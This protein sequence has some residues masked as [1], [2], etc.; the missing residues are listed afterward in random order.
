MAKARKKPSKRKAKERTKPTSSMPHVF[1]LKT[2]T[3]G[4]C[5]F[6]EEDF[7]PLE[8]NLAGAINH[9]VQEHD[10]ELLHI[11]TETSLEEDKFFHVSVAFLEA[12]THPPERRPKGS[13]P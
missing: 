2:N 1:S 12:I 8:S 11:G 13:K 7:G 10:C 5:V 4:Q 9:Y 6:C 3:V